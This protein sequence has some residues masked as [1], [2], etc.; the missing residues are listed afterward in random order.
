[1]MLFCCD[2]V[3]DFV[4]QYGFRFVQDAVMGSGS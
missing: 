2:A 3:P 4:T 1:V